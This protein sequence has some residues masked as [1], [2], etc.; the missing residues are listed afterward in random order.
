[1]KAK[2]LLGFTIAILTLTGCSHRCTSPTVAG[3]PA[4]T[5][6]EYRMQH[7]ELLSMEE[8][9]H[10]RT[11]CRI[12]DPWHSG[13]VMMQY[14]LV[15]DTDTNWS[16]S[17]EQRLSQDYGASIVLRTP[18]RRM[19]LT[20]GCHAWLLSQL[21][22]LDRVAVMCDT[23]YV[24]ADAV[25]R[26]MRSRKTDGTPTVL[27]GGLATAPNA[28]VLMA[29]GCDALWVNPYENASLP[30]MAGL[31]IPIIYCAEYMESDPLARA[32]WMRFFGR[33]VGRGE[34][35][36]ALFEAIERRYNAAR[37]DST[38]RQTILAELPFGATWYVPGGASTS[39]RLYAD[40][41]FS[42]PWADDSHAGSLALSHE[43]VL[44]K[45]QQCDLWLIKYMNADHDWSLSEL[46]V[47][48]PLFAQ[49]RAA[50]QGNVW[51]CNTTRSDFFDVTPFRP[52]SLLESL[53]RQDGAFFKRLE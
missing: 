45:A 48:S 12:E 6:R 29:A 49:F 41:G 37:R 8:L 19:A 20:S 35:A 4:D 15:P 17:E 9:H 42:Y 13:R 38:T 22:A 10:G 31:P 53:T 2:Y 43:A 39:A 32:E 5:V 14:L 50:Q 24:M 40:A 21:G 46:L 33:L 3:H 44:A 16:E 28:E 51:G 23:A 18:L 7:A 36:D 27:D 47:Q 30:G 11:L 1:M 26:W 34:E 25:R 52:D